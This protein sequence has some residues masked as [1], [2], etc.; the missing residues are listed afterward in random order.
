MRFVGFMFAA[1]MMLEPGSVAEL[2]RA[3]GTAQQ[4]TAQQKTFMSP[5]GGFRFSHP[6]DFPICTKA[7]IN[8]CTH[9][10]ISV[11]DDDALVCVVYPPERFA[12]TNFGSAGFQVRKV[13]WFPPLPLPN[14]ANVCV[15]PMPVVEANGHAEPDTD[16]F[17]SAD[18]PAEIIGGTSFIHGIRGGAA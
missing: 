14:T 12:D 2:P 9:S 6:K 5:D 10:Y 13:R 11:C 1:I 15:T 8:E 16:F 7:N 4:A 17:I 3:T 18:H